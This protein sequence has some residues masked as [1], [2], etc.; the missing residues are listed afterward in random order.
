[1][2]EGG[3]LVDVQI[4]V[5]VGSADSRFE[6]NAELSLDE[7][8]LVLFGPSGCGKSLTLQAVVGVV[9]P[10]SGHIHVC[11]ATMFDDGGVWVP[12]HQRRIGYVPQHHSLFPFCNVA[13][14][15]AF[16][17]PR[18]ERR[19][20]NKRVE[21]LIEELGIAHLRNTMPG[22]LSGGERQRVALARAL[23]VRPRL[24]V[25]DEPFASIDHEGRDELRQMLRRTLERHGTPALFVT[26]DP[27]EARQLAD[28]VV[29][30]ERGK[31]TEA[32]TATELLGAR[33]L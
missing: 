3:P 2:S 21:E 24:L 5:A 8:V 14:N 19:S 23:A 16:G 25:L 15:V 22:N 32:G 6:L 17:L 33:T 9:R 28:R 7:G 27:N 30:F 26:H 4:R 31:T 29:R 1:M 11:G 10:S 18:A 20:G 13:D 12:A